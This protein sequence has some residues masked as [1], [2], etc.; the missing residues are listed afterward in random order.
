[1]QQSL[2]TARATH[3]AHADEVL[4]YEAEVLKVIRGESSLN[5]ELLNKLHSE[6][7][8]K[9]EQAAME[10]RRLEERIKDNAR[11]QEELAGQYD[12]IMSW[13]QLY[14]E[15][16]HDTRKMIVAKLCRAVRVK[17]DYQI[18]IALSVDCQ[19]LGIV[20]KELNFG[21]MPTEN[22]REAA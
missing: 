22:K 15:C 9:A 2:I 7:K 5:A 4:S 10:V 18:E 13:A 14:D 8:E 6:A 12:N 17:R 11:L 1:L 19:Q 3:Q 16:D 21:D 20:P